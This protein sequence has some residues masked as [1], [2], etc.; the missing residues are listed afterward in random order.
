MKQLLI[1]TL[2]LFSIFNSIGS[3]KIGVYLVSKNEYKDL[4]A[5]TKLVD[6]AIVNAFGVPNEDNDYKFNIK[7][8]DSWNDQVSEFRYFPEVDVENRTKLSKGVLASSKNSSIKFRVT[9]NSEKS[10]LTSTIREYLDENSAFEFE[11]IVVGDDRIFV[12]EAIDKD[13][14]NDILSTKTFVD[15][16]FKNFFGVNVMN[17][18]YNIEVLG[19]SACLIKDLNKQECSQTYNM[20]ASDSSY[21]GF[22][23]K[24][25]SKEFSSGFILFDVL[26]SK[27]KSRLTQKANDVIIRDADRSEHIR[28]YFCIPKYNLKPGS[29][30]YFDIEAKV[31]TSDKKPYA[32][33]NVELR[34]ASNK[35]VASQKTDKDGYI[36]F[37]NVDEGMTYTLFIDKSYKEEGLK[38]TSKA[39]KTVGLF[40]KGK[41]GSEYKLLTPVIDTLEVI[42]VKESTDDVMVKIKARIVSVSD[43]INP[44]ADQKVELRDFQNKVLQ[45]KMTD[46][47]GDFEFSDVNIKEIYSVE[48]FEY[49]EKF[50]N[51]KLYISNTKNELVA[52]ISKDANGKFSYKTIPADL[53]YL[54]DMKSEDVSLTLKKQLK[55]SENIM[56]I[57]DL[58]NYDLN[59]AVISADAK[60]ILNKII[61]LANENIESNLEIISHTDSR[62]E[63]SDNLKLS[64]KR[65]DAVVEYFMANGVDKNRLRSIGMG[66]TSPLNSCTDGVSC[67]EDEYKMNRR[68]EFRFYK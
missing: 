40:K 36:K 28:F 59:S 45:T 2:L 67:T 11:I 27:D 19:T 6:R 22:C 49:K 52:R 15:K 39:D 42:A 43:K 4:E 5:G 14:Y 57:R 63:A 12:T 33:V 1:L 61:K 41:L 46:K 20:S 62:G 34:D 68:T 54:S 50:K 13:V 31:V 53:V 3:N 7:K 65:S 37:F 32:N 44:I 51:E 8:I 23:N 38:L 26:V 25:S 29:G 48:L 35:I 66:E 21:I 58:I 60:V 18:N 16:A 17:M 24:I 64:Q 47:Y 10:F 9:V 55:L 30:R 56:V